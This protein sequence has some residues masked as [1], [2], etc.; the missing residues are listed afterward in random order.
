V[1]TKKDVMTKIDVTK[2]DIDGG[3][4]GNPFCC[5]IAIAMHRV[6]EISPPQC[7][8]F[9]SEMKI[10]WRNIPLPNEAKKFVDRFDAGLDVEPFSFEVLVEGWDQN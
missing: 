9:P 2:Q 8:V 7:P 5:P 4:R 6:L 10:G 3:R 1:S